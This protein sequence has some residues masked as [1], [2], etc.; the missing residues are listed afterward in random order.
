MATIKN[1]FLQP[2]TLRDTAAEALAIVRA[3]AVL[4]IMVVMAVAAGA[5]LAHLPSIVMLGLAF[6]A[7]LSGRVFSMIFCLMVALAWFNW[8]WGITPV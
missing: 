5:A 3:L 1:Y 8:L 2:I 4:A 6:V 7:L